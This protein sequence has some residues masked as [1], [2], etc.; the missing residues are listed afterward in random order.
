[1]TLFNLLGIS[2]AIASTGAAAQ[3]PSLSTFL[4]YMVLIGALFYFMIFRPQNKQAKAQQS[5]LSDLAKGDEVV[6]SGEH[7]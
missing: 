7:R 6:T 1:M 2:D 5:L 4:P 3:A